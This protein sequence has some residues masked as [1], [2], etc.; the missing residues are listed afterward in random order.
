[1]Y[2]STRLRCRRQVAVTSM[3]LS[4]EIEVKISLGYISDNKKKCKMSNNISLAPT[5]PNG[6]FKWNKKKIKNL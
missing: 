4:V 1:M 2:A 5:Y 6:G 3:C